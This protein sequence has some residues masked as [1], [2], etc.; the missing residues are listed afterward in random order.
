[1]TAKNKSGLA[2]TLVEMLVVMA[3][4]GVLAALL[5]TALGAA[6]ASAKQTAC[7]DNLKQINYATRMYYDDSNDAS[8][9][10][11]FDET[12]MIAY[13]NRI[14]NYLG[15]KGHSSP[16]DKIFACPADTFFYCPTVAGEEA[17][18]FGFRLTNAPLHEYAKWNHTSYW[19]NGNNLPP[20]SNSNSAPRLGIAGLKLTS[21]REPVK[22][23]LVFEAPAWLP[24]SWH[25]PRLGEGPMFNDAKDVVSFVD[26]HASYIKIYYDNLLAISYNPPAGYDY[27]WSGD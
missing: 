24:F 7:L 14:R 22:T 23:L 16:Q 20:R 15:L 26:G 21:I 1:M 8:P 2:F 3:I 9:N 25:Q 5:L 6:K 19:F 11:G 18:P 10:A 13:K 12:P 17:P 4:I 27:K